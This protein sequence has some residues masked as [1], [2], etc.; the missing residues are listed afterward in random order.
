MPHYARLKRFVVEHIEQG[1]WKAHQRIP[2]EEELA[3]EFSLSRMTVNRALRE[4]AAEGVITRLQGVGS[5]VAG[6]KGESTLVE[7]RNIHD[8]ILARGHA[9]ATDVLEAG[10]IEA[11]TALAAAFQVAPGARLFRSRL[12]HRENGE[13]V[14]LEERVVNPACAPDYLSLDF[15]AITPHAHLMQVAPLQRAEHVVEAL[16]ASAAVARLLAIGTLEPCLVLHRRTWSRGLVASVARLTH[17]G[18]RY[19]L[20]GTADTGWTLGAGD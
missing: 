15:R 7:V 8:E 1:S 14:Q 9:H 5:F 12:V 4:L 18:S 11:T 16:P 13:A 19:R 2:S 17:P 6:P 10:R 3:R 20:T